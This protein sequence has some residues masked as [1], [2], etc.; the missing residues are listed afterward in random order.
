MELALLQA[1]I[2]CLT[3]G[4]LIF[5]HQRDKCQCVLGGGNYK[6]A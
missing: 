5:N 4:L 6:Y 2:T 1:V 3:E